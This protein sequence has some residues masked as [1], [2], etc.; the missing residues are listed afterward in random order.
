MLHNSLMSTRVPGGT[1]Q[2]HTVLGGCTHT[3]V[4]GGTA[5]AHRVPGGTAHTHCVGRVP[6]GTARTHQW[7]YTTY[8]LRSWRLVVV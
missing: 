5:H 7:L 3:R 2:A 1:A 8:R 4:P 6:G